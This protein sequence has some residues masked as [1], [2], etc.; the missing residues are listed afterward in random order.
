M[1]KTPNHDK[2]K[3]QKGLPPNPFPFSLFT[4]NPQANTSL[5][6]W[7]DMMIIQ[8][9]RMQLASSHANDVLQ[10]LPMEKSLARCYITYIDQETHKL[11][12]G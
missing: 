3:R 9:Y 12:P 6:T 4:A 10:Q 1:K 8:T 7:K 11:Y 2:L 5:F